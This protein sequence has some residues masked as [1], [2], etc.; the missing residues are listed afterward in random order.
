MKTQET[1][2]EKRVDR[3]TMR[4]SHARHKKVDQTSNKQKHA[5]I[6]SK[7]TRHQIPQ[8]TAN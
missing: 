7:S 5:R 3:W 4:T 8:Q 2:N 6:K 1:L